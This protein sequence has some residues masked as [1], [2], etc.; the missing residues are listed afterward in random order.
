MNK[1]YH[2][3]KHFFEYAIQ[4]LWTAGSD[5]F[6]KLDHVLI[7]CILFIQ[8]ANNSQS[9]DL[10]G[11]NFILLHWA[12]IFHVIHQSELTALFS[13]VTAGYSELT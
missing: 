4:G 10:A 2:I 13:K 12:E 7:K 5:G 8:T 9:S 3:F 1:Y 6:P 11:Q